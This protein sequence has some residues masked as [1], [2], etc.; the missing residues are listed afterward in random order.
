MYRLHVYRS[1][2]VTCNTNRESLV[3]S[4]SKRE[5]SPRTPHHELTIDKCAGDRIITILWGPS[6]VIRVNRRTSQCND[7]DYYSIWRNSPTYRS[8][9]SH[10]RVHGAA[11]R[12]VALLEATYYPD[13]FRP[14]IESVSQADQHDH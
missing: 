14:P 9:S 1:E 10:F 6:E 5:C 4:L 8:Y 13:R 12:A 11:P 3:R 2:I 7:D